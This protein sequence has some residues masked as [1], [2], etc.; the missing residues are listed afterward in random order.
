MAI[1]LVNFYSLCFSISLTT[2]VPP[3]FRPHYETISPEIHISGGG[4]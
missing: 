2:L 4:I 3:D 1:D